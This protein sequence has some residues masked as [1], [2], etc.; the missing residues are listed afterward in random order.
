VSFCK[1]P[2]NREAL[3]EDCS[4]CQRNASERIGDEKILAAPGSSLLE[5]NSKVARVE[6]AKEML[7]ILQE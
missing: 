4:H 6:A 7:R 3:P 1:F 2:H 5:R